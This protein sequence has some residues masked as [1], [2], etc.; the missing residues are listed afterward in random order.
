MGSFWTERREL[1]RPRVSEMSSESQVEVPGRNR[2]LPRPSN[3]EDANALF[4]NDEQ[5]TARLALG[6]FEKR[7]AQFQPHLL[8]FV[9]KWKCLTVRSEGRQEIAKGS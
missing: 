1:R 3:R 8:G 7:L 2:G 4:L 9:G 6:R 5:S